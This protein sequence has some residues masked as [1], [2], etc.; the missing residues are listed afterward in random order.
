M[1]KPMLPNPGGKLMPDEIIGRDKL[2]RQILDILERQ[3]LVLTAERRIGKTQLLNKMLAEHEIE[4]HFIYQDLESIRTADE[5]AEDIFH[6]ALPSLPPKEKAGEWIRNVLGQMKKINIKDFGVEWETV[7]LSWKEKL[8]LSF[9]ALDKATS[10]PT[11]LL[12]DELPLMLD[13]IMRSGKMEDAMNVLDSLRTFR[14]QFP[15][16]RMIYTGSIG[17]HHIINRLK[18]MGYA[19]DPTNDMYLI[20]VPPLAEQDAMNLCRALLA[21]AGVLTDSPF[22]IARAVALSVDNIAFYIH[23]VAQIMQWEYENVTEATVEKIIIEMLTHDQDSYH[24]KHYES[25]VATYYHI[26]DQQLVLGILDTFAMAEE[27]L[28]FSTAFNLL[29]A[30]VVTEDAEKVRDLLT[31]LRSDHY[32]QQLPDGTYQFRFGIIKRWWRLHRGEEVT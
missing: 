11:V 20:E 23:H 2:I 28:T 30:R 7:K 17:L 21:G 15:A 32:L 10:R 31:L 18:V 13:N 4:F 19:N 9:A 26:E 16:L 25:R 14:Q 24:F 3:S 29:K 12:W 1:L 5:F 8:Q 6:K 27:P 22:P